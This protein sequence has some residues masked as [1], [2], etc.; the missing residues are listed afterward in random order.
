MAS[1][2]PALTPVT[3]SNASGRTRSP[4]CCWD[5]PFRKPAPNAPNGPPEERARSRRRLSSMTGSSASARSGTPAG[6]LSAF[7]RM[8]AR[9]CSL[10]RS[11]AMASIGEGASCSL[12]S[13]SVVR[14]R[15]MGPS[16]FGQRPL[17][18]GPIGRSDEQAASASARQRGVSQRRHDIRRQ[19]DMKTPRSCWFAGTVPGCRFYNPP[20]GIRPSFRAIRSSA[21]PAGPRPIGQ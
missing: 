16:G 3:T 4:L 8:R 6:T 19:H 11:P 17:Q 7:R 9:T 10:S 21:G 15:E 12:A 13:S 18:T 5:Q 1:K 2:A 14:R 20:S